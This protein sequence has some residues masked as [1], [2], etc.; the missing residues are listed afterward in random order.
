M[1][2]KQILFNVSLPASGNH[3]SAVS[4]VTD[5]ALQE[6]G[7]CCQSATDNFETMHRL[8]SFLRSN[9]YRIRTDDELMRV[10]GIFEKT[11]RSNTS[12]DSLMRYAR[13]LRSLL[14]CQELPDKFNMTNGIAVEFYEVGDHVDGQFYDTDTS[15][16]WE[17]GLVISTR[18]S[19]QAEPYEVFWIGH[20]PK[21]SGRNRN[22][23]WVSAH[24]LRQHAEGAVIG[25]DSD[26]L[27]LDKIR[28]YKESIKPQVVEEEAA[29]SKLGNDE[30][31]TENTRAGSRKSSRNQ[32]PA[33][34]AAPEPLC[35]KKPV[36]RKKKRQVRDGEP[37]EDETACTTS[38]I[39][40]EPYFELPAP[41]VRKNF[42]L[43]AAATPASS[44]P[45]STAALEH[46][47]WSQGHWNV[48]DCISTL[49]ALARTPSDH[50][51]CVQEYEVAFEH[52]KGRCQAL[53]RLYGNPEFNTLYDGAVNALAEYKGRETG[54]TK[55]FVQ[56]HLRKYGFFITPRMWSK[57]EILLIMCVML[58]TS[59]VY[60][61]INQ[62][63]GPESTEHF[64]N[65]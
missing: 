10:K 17:A 46:F 60:Q 34:P 2:Q 65:R 42:D 63:T 1:T 15:F 43:A 51:E 22:P 4:K 44:F 55:A 7:S 36:G 30:A 11:A 16:N 47:Y 12:P 26:W 27:C 29:S 52:L 59:L 35:K 8:V 38:N 53:A 13:I 45:K 31:A 5:Q 21:K 24:I 37:E 25:D 48:E 57:L 20:P 39:V 32:V 50:S 28:S 64:Q 40:T 14:S 49:E 62:K 56:G 33:P 54:Q 19:K 23:T 58:D 3:S 9:E 41:R 6:F 61:S 18:C